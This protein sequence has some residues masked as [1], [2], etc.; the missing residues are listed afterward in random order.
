MPSRVAP[1]AAGW[2]RWASR[3]LSGPLSGASTP[4]L[5]LTYDEELSRVR[6][7]A[8]GLGSLAT[9]A[10][11]DRS[12]DGIR[13]TTVRGAAA[14]SLAADQSLPATLDDYEFPLGAVT[15]RVRSFNAAG[16]LELTVTAT[17]ALALDRV[18]LKSIVR[19]FLNRP[20]NV[21]GWSDVERPARS[22]EFDVV[23]RSFP[24]AL[25]DVRGSR[26]W[27]L[28]LYTPTHVE[29]QTM[30]YVLAAGDVMFVHTPADCEIPGGYVRIGDTNERRPH[31]RAASRVFALPLAEVAAPGP[32]VAGSTST[33]AT[34]LASY[35]S[36]AQL[37]A[38]NPTWADLL[39][40][41]A[42]PSMVVV[43]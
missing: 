6:I 35:A 41:I 17:I 11:V 7:T 31:V 39:E 12:V 2:N 15:Y 4:S 33:W 32:D 20:V 18:W 43:P 22:A 21:V 10:V 13:W 34:V 3:N 30:D 19:P 1:H 36:W 8:A 16:G 38:A 27:T 40:Q 37:L 5:T 23:G 29:A 26:R 14:I 28:S 24:I 42:D 9:Y 25:S